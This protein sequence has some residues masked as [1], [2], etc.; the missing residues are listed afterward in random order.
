MRHCV[1]LITHQHPR[2]QS[3]P[4]SLI[5]PDQWDWHRDF[6]PNSIIRVHPGGDH[7]L[8]SQV[9]LA[10]AFL[11]DVDQTSGATALLDGSHRAAGDYHSLK[12]RYVKAQPEMASGSVLLLSEALLHAATPVIGPRRREA[13]LTWMTA[14]WFGGDNVAPFDVLRWKDD[15]LKNIFSEPFFGDAPI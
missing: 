12:E 14:P 2:S 1:A 3:D 11:S 6:T 5:D 8:T 13:V 10:A 4:G 7:L 15:E 9:I